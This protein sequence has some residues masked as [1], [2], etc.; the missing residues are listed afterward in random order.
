M[1]NIWIIMLPIVLL[2]VG[3]KETTKNEM[4]QVPYIGKVESIADTLIMDSYELLSLESNDNSLISRID[5]VIKYENRYY[6]LDKRMEPLLAFDDS[7]GHLFTIHAVGSGI[8]EYANLKDFSIDKEGCWLL[9][10]VDPSAILYYDLSEG[11]YDHKLK[12]DNYYDAI[13]NDSQN[14]YLE[15]ATYV[16]NKLS[17]SAITVMR[18]SDNV[19]NDILKP[20][21]E[22]AP[23]C[24]AQG[25]RMSATNPLYFTRK[26][27]DCIYKLGYG[28]LE[29][30][31]HIDWKEATFPSLSE[32][33]TYEC[34]KLNEMARKRGY[35][36]SISDLQDS[37]ENIL[38]RT[39]L[40]GLFRL[41]KRMNSIESYDLIFNTLD[42]IPLPN[43]VP[44]GGD[45]NE[46]FFVY[47]VHL[48]KEQMNRK[49]SNRLTTLLEFMNEDSN[50]IIFKYN[51]K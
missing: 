48:L 26:F 23:Y 25:V 44:V 9:L 39:N 4:L 17:P 5:R 29:P 27:D 19:M 33:D 32:K 24:H 30:L 14:I 37:G 22:I 13:T 43:Y 6:V 40:P 49:L 1:K 41:S 8:G 51:L 3:C 20:L 46:V 31:Y 21:T 50:P 45:A 35:V 12:L 11:K 34:R 18:K 2:V 42:S 28:T 38:F 47:P 36:W 10:L 15:R 16:N 7:G